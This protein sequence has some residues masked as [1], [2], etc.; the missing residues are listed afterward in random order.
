MQSCSNVGRPVFLKFVK[1]TRHVQKH[2][3][4]NCVNTAGSYDQTV[5]TGALSQV[6]SVTT[7]GSYGQTVNTGTQNSTHK[8]VLNNESNTVHVK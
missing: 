4:E 8:L 5:N 1:S 6:S 2:S 3:Q 7:T